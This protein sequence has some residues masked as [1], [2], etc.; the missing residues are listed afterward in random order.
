MRSKGAKLAFDRYSDSEQR[1]SNRGPLAGVT[2]ATKKP[3]RLYASHVAA[4]V[5]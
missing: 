5:P 3:K 1:R 2:S 4:D